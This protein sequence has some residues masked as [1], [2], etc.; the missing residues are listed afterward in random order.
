MTYFLQFDRL[1]TF[2]ALKVEGQLS[3]KHFNYHN[4]FFMNTM[5]QQSPLFSKT[6]ILDLGLT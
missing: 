5:L 1:I 3:S 4:L 6:S 2:S